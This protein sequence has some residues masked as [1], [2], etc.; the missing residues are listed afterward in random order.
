MFARFF[1]CVPWG[2]EFIK[3]EII[4]KE[5]RKEGEKGR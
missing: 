3:I 1:C 5:V 4:K 2:K